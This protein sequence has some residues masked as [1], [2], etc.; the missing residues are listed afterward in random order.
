MI[1][2]SGSCGCHGGVVGV[3]IISWWRSMAEGKLFG[4]CCSELQQLVTIMSS[5]LD[6]AAVRGR[7]C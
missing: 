3:V 7:A 4:Q 6:L 5:I 1:G 2:A